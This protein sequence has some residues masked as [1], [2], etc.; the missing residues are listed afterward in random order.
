MAEFDF[1]DHSH[2]RYNPLLDSWVLVSPHRTKRPWQGQQEAPGLL[3]LPDYDAKCYLCPRNTRASGD[4]NPDYPATFAFVNDYSAVREDQPDYVSPDDSGDARSRLMK[5]KGVRGKCFVICFSPKHNVTLPLMTQDEIVAVIQTWSGLYADMKLRSDFQ[6]VQI[7]ENKGA[8]MGCSNPH[9]HCQA[10][11]T[12]VV[13]TEPAQ[14]LASM[15][16]YKAEHGSCL[17]CDYTQLE[18]ADPERQVIANDSFVVVVP[19]WAVWPFETLVLAKEHVGALADMSPKQ[20]AD[21][22]DVLQRLTRRYDNL[23]KTSF[24]YSMGMHQTPLH[25]DDGLSHFHMHF[26]PPLLRSATVR[27]FLVGFEMLGEPQRD[28]SAEK[29]AKTLRD[30]SEVHYLEA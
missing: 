21:L 4:V 28:L 26:Y 3:E 24:P 2:R 7:F 16:R 13:P 23:F 6:Y 17:L 1:D 5:V 25:A 15:G 29:A 19:F 30:Q 8:S 10:W 27:K 18:L 22:A 12:D 9:P 11:C 14:E 20:Q